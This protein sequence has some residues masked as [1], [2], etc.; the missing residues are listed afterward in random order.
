MTRQFLPRNQKFVPIEAADLS[1]RRNVMSLLMSIRL[2]DLST[3]PSGVIEGFLHLLQTMLSQMGHQII[4]FVPQFT[5]IVLALCSMAAGG[6]GSSAGQT[7]HDSEIVARAPNDLVGRYSSIRSLGYQLLSELFGRFCAAVD[8]SDFVLPTWTAL[9]RSVQLLPEMVM[10]TEKPPSILILFET[11]SADWRLIKMLAAH[12][13]AVES[14]IRCISGT[15]LVPVV[16]SSLTFVENL[17]TVFDPSSESKR[18]GLQMIRKYIP[19]LL[20]QFTLRLQNGSDNDKDIRPTKGKYW[21]R[22]SNRH[23]TWRRELDILCRVSELL[24]NEDGIRLK[25]KSSVLADLFSLLLPF[26]KPEQM[27]S[28]DD[29]MNIIGILRSTVSQLEKEKMADVFSSIAGIL[30]PARGKAGIESLVVR[31]GVASLADSIAIEDSQYRMVADRLVKLTAMHTKRVDEMDFDVVIP[32]LSALSQPG[33]NSGWINLCGNVDFSPPL[34]N[35]LISTCFQFLHNGDGVIL[36]L[37]FNSLK[38]LIRL[39]AQKSTCDG[40]SK[41]AK[42]V[43]SAVVPLARA[44]LQARDQSVRRYYILLIREISDSFKK[45]PSPNLCG[46]LHV[47]IDEENPDLDFFLNIT[48]VQIHRRARGFQRLRKVVGEAV[49]ESKVSPFSLQSLSN[50]LLPIALHPVYECKTKA[51]EPFALE[52]IATVGSIS[53]L[54]SW[55]KYNNM[56]WTMLTHFERYPEQERFLIGAIC[57]TID[58]FGYDLTIAGGDDKQNVNDDGEGGD[59]KTSVWISLEKRTIPKIEGLLTKETKD[60]SGRRTKT[61]RPTIILAL[62]KLFQKFPTEFFESK[63]PQ[64]LSVIC[65]AL[66]DKD[67]NARDVARKTLAKMV[68]S[69]DLKYLADVLR[70]VA[71]TLTEGYKL[72][73]RAA[74]IHTILQELSK[75]YEPSF[76]NIPHPLY[77]D[78]CTAALMELIQEDLF[79]EANERRESK[80]TSVRFVKEAGGSKS[81]DSIEMVCRM[82]AFK[83]LDASKSSPNRSSVH[84]IVS[85]LLERLRRHDVEASTIRKI[86]QIL[87]RVVVGFSCNSS[88]RAGQLFPFVYATIEPFVGAQTIAAAQRIQE[89]DDEDSDVEDSLRPIQISGARTGRDKSATESSGKGKVTEWRP[90]TL[91]A[92]TSSEA[93]LKLKRDDTRE[94][95]KVIDGA[96]APKLTGSSRHDTS[97]L[98]SQHDLN[99]P[100]SISAVIFGLNLLNSC[101]K[102]L[103]LLDDSM[104]SMM[105]PFVPL[106]TACV[107]CSRDSEVALVGLKCLMSFLRFD[108]PSIASCS[109]SLGTQALTLLTSSGSSLNQSPDLM[110]ACFRTLTYLIKSDEDP[111]AK[112]NKDGD[113]LVEGEHVLAK[114]K[115]L[116]LNSDQMKV[117]ISTLQLSVA[118]SDQHNPALGLIKAIL[119]RKY[120]SPEM[121]DLME[122]MLKLV[123]RSHTTALRHVSAQT[124]PWVVF[125]HTAVLTLSGNAASYSKALQFLFVTY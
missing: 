114:N 117:L 120:I 111:S 75:T 99:D 66:R 64:L 28:D 92:A 74:V 59:T 19:L 76:A 11:M 63:L 46:D 44:G 41:W 81:L 69:M 112:L 108:L 82:V 51:E 40:G 93:A 103:N 105:D 42:L 6:A 109:K 23:S 95:H 72:H 84:C 122:A 16:N 27:T 36:R 61:I 107:C 86:R 49:A 39:A 57:A 29:K 124:R 21:S 91:K 7:E 85:P 125:H 94:L 100:A 15:S 83:P 55:S 118:E 13:A 37:S 2:V 56:L 3:L 33:G 77:F 54:L 119:S 78:S 26:L 8:F 10:N 14:V 12:D 102:K 53:R 35:P 97:N 71:I 5:S 48:H 116:P 25:H 65:D 43:E 47:L 87:T 32:E 45:N 17:L 30:A 60:S 34:L 79:G 50:I 110:Q 80:D 88:V 52:A 4:M 98:G 101:L 90:S 121:Y 31:H 18:A 58:G 89:D 106:L 113:I 62:L 9:E 67:S 115:R 20:E 70:E 73:V 24:S 104:P 68:V 96:S 1:D 22:S 123:V 38:L